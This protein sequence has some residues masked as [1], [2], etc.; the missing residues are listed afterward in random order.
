MSHGMDLIISVLFSKNAFEK[1]F[2]KGRW[3][4]RELWWKLF[5]KMKTSGK[6]LRYLDGLV[7]GILFYTEKNFLLLWR[8]C[9]LKNTK[10]FTK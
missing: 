10:C 4:S 9:A 1:W 8:G 5:L 6:L 7:Q 2:L 3:L